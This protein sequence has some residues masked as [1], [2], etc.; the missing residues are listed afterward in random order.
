MRKVFIVFL[1]IVAAACAKVSVETA[2]PIKVD[3]TMRVDIYQHVEKDVD[4]IMDEIYGEGDTQLNAIFGLPTVYAA[5]LTSAERQAIDRIKGRL[6]KIE[7]YFRQ[8]YIGENKDALLEAVGEVPATE[9]EGVESLI[10]A[11]NQDRQILYKATAE[12]NNAPLAGVRQLFFDRHYKQAEAGYLFQVY[13]E[14]S[15]SY[16]WQKK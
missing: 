1:A 16:I 10:E 4:S 8:G 12:R 7:H 9:Q 3:I 5:D 13:Q 15:A 11:E 14:D 6:D 2:K